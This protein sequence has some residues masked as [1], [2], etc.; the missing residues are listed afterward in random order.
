MKKGEVRLTLMLG[1]K[2]FC[3]I[4]V[5]VRVLLLYE[6]EGVEVGLCAGNKQSTNTSSE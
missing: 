2:C 1:S 5:L 4:V 3:V 6:L